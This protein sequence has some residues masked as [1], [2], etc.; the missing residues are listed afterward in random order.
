MRENYLQQ[1][2]TFSREE[3]WEKAVAFYEEAIPSGSA[4]L[5][6]IEPDNCSGDA[7][8]ELQRWQEAAAAYNQS[9]ERKSDFDC[10]DYNLGHALVKLEKRDEAHCEA[11]PLH[12]II[13][14]LAN[15]PGF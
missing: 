7:P 3:D 8:S 9:L 11:D 13:P 1:G 6:A 12:N 10:S 2:E 14:K 4:K 5:C 15:K